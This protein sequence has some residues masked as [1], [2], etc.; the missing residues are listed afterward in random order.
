M[1]AT[2]EPREV[3]QGLADAILAGEWARVRAVLADDTAWY[4]GGASSLAGRYRGPDEVLGLLE[5]ISRHGFERPGARTG[6][7]EI[8]VGEHHHGIFWYF[9]AEVDGEKSWSY[10][11]WLA[12]LDADGRVGAVFFFSE[13]DGFAR[14]FWS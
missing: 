10:E 2:S 5:T 4:V 1:D 12:E 9:N 14:R 13:D 3:L 8:L 11:I 7:A 6:P